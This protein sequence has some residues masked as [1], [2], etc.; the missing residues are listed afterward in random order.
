MM[1]NQ[2]IAIVLMTLL[3]VAWFKYFV[4]T[5]QPVKPSPATKQAASKAAEKK[6]QA[7]T[8]RALEKKTDAV[9]QTWPT[10]PP[11]PEDLDPATDEIAISNDS[12]EL[13]FTR[14]GGRL[15]Q[16]RLILG[17]GAESSVQLVPPETQADTAAVYPMGLRFS[18]PGLGDALDRRRFEVELDPSG[19]A[20]VFSLTIPEKAIVRKRFSLEDKH[21]VLQAQVEYENLEPQSR[22]MGMDQTPAYY[23]NWGPNIQSGDEALGLKQSLMWRAAGQVNE[24]A[25][26][27]MSPGQDGEDFVK[28]LANPDWWA[29]RSAYFVV[30]FKPEFGATQGWASGGPKHFRFGLATPRFEVASQAVQTNSFQVYLGPSEQGS[31]AQAWDTLPSILRFFSPPWGF[32][33]SFA[34]LLLR[35]LN[36]FHAFIPNYGIGIILLTIL[37]RLGMYPLTLKSMK[38]MKK[39]QMLGPEM[40]EIKTKYAEDSQEMNKRIME[41]YRER[42]VNPVGGCLPMMLQMPVFIALYRMLWCAYELRGA[43]FFGWM[44]DLSQADKMFHMPWMKDVPFIGGTFEY[45]NLLP[46]LMGVAMLL[47]Q[48]VMPTTGPMQNP[49]QK[50]MMNIMPV[51]FSFICYKMASGLNL[52]ILTS[53]ILGM[54]QQRFTRVNEAELKEKKPL[55]KRQHF[56][57]AAQSRKRQMTREAK[58]EKKAGTGPAVAEETWLTKIRDTIKR[59]FDE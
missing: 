36:W 33:D 12:L 23:L 51:F 28:T 53:T 31:L 42:G 26:A 5:A 10:L 35:I 30:A 16:A 56:Y 43:P 37:V 6:N 47:S 8:S 50:M 4:P 44:T 55:L 13:V 19:L 49:Q 29:I 21:F 58:K 32:M 22:I 7:E 18:E 46:I 17:K 41:L 14:I 9:E 59:P 15:K 1:R 57:T 38:S 34:K 54:V 39:M 2:M 11:V 24:L 52:Y 48:K 45:F 25:T 27:S 3:F 40:E 20:L